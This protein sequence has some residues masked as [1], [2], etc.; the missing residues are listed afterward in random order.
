VGF[1]DRLF[2]RAQDSS[3][4]DKAQELAAEH[5]DAV[6]SGVGKAADFV[7]EKTGG[8]FSEQIEQVEDVAAD[9]VD[10]VSGGEAGDEPAE[11][12]AAEPGPDDAQA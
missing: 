11:A 4:V 8:R 3:V 2:R 1:F 9:V 6:K 10:T 12:A 5:A 7:D